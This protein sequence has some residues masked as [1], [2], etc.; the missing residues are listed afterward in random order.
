[1]HDILL[2]FSWYKHASLFGD[3]NRVLQAAGS[4][5]IGIDGRPADADTPPPA[6][7]VVAP[8]DGQLKQQS[9]KFQVAIEIGPIIFVSKFVARP[10]TL[11]MMIRFKLNFTHEPVDAGNTASAHGR[12]IP[13]LQ[14]LGCCRLRLQ[15][16]PGRNRR[17]G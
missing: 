12:K 5:S 7:Q 4:A 9:A 15:Q 6:D 17:P 11:E 16:R 1:V 2:I 10:T 8:P 3:A 13:K 14:S